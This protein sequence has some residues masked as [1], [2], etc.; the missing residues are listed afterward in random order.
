[1]TG[2]G[3]AVVYSV[4]AAPNAFALTAL[5]GSTVQETLKK[6]ISDMCTSLEG[7]ATGSGS[8]NHDQQEASL[9]AEE[10]WGTGT[11]GL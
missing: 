10:G 7:T 2:L 11:K 8:P 3:L 9:V 1:M 6:E 4:P 5:S